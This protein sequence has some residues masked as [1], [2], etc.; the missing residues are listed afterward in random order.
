MPREAAPLHICGG[1]MLHMSAAITSLCQGTTMPVATQTFCL[2]MHIRSLQTQLALP[3]NV[4]RV[5][6]V[7]SQT[8]AR[9]QMPEVAT[10]Q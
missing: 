7:T 1:E 10:T 9:L 6:A 3:K 5:T 8:L 2:P 4:C